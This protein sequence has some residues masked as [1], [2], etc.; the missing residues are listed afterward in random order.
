MKLVVVN[1][2]VNLF[3]VATPD[4]VSIVDFVRFYK[5][6]DGCTAVAVIFGKRWLRKNRMSR[7]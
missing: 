7:I 5:K 4:S 3:G 2:K 6:K 1:L